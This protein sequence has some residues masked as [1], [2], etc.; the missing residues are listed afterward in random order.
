MKLDKETIKK[1]RELLVFAV[2]VVF[3]FWHLPLIIQGAQR[4]FDV[5]YP[6]LL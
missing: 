5:L 6:F 1:L 3:S 4:I 2:I